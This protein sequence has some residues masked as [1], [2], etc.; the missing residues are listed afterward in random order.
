MALVVIATAGV[1]FWYFLSTRVRQEVH[2]SEAERLRPYEEAATGYRLQVEQ[3]KNDVAR[4]TRDLDDSNKERDRLQVKLRELESD[5]TSLAQT[6]YKQ[7]GEIDRLK[8]Q[9]AD[10]SDLRGQLLEALARLKG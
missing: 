9:V 7:Q 5:Y 2:E 6:N 3:L 8:R 10:M 1:V 4:L